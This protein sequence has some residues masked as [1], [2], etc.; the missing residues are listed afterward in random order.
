[1]YG[2]LLPL[3]ADVCEE[4]ATTSHGLLLGWALAAAGPWAPV[5]VAAPA[6]AWRSA[7]QRA[8]CWIALTAAVAGAF[9]C[10]TGWRLASGAW[11]VPFVEP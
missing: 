11:F 5:I 3:A 2:F 8:I 9:L 10:L 4:C 6:M 1:M 7:R